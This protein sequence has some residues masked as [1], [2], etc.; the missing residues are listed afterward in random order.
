LERKFEKWKLENNEL[1]QEVLLCL[2][3]VRIKNHP[4][5]NLWGDLVLNE[6]YYEDKL[7]SYIADLKRIKKVL[8]KWLYFLFIQE[9]K[10]YREN[11]IHFALKE[12]FVKV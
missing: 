10:K 12:F 5:F 1:S 3:L 9:S 6:N 8:K 4:L 11:E 7:L 2:K